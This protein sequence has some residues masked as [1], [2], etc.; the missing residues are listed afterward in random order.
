MNE[1]QGTEGDRS[2][3]SYSV[4]T[5][6]DSYSVRTLRDSYSVRTLRDSYSVRTLRDSYRLYCVMRRQQFG[7]SAL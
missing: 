4:R 3:G 1:I 5:L 2:G 6:R 7:K